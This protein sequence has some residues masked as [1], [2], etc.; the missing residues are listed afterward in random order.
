MLRARTSVSLL[1]VG[2]GAL[3]SGGC[4]D[5]APGGKATVTI[6]R[7]ERASGFVLA[8]TLGLSWGPTAEQKPYCTATLVSSEPPIALTAAHCVQRDGPRVSGVFRPGEPNFV[9]FAPGVLR[10]VREAIPH[11]DWT[12]S[13][14]DVAV[15]TFE[16]PI[17]AGFSPIRIADSETEIERVWS[18]QPQESSGRTVSEFVIAGYGA[19][20]TQGLQ[21]DD[22]LSTTVGLWK[23]WRTGF[24]LG[25][26][27]FESPEG[28]GACYGDSGGPAYYSIDG[29]WVLAGVTHGSHAAF[30]R[31]LPQSM[32]GNCDVGKSIY[33]S[34]ARYKDWIR[35]VV[36]GAKIAGDAELYT[37]WSGTSQ[38]ASFAEA[39]RAGEGLVWDQWATVLQLLL[40]AGTTNCDAAERFFR[41]ATFGDVGG[42]GP[43]PL[44]LTSGR[45]TRFDPAVLPVAPGVR[46]F[47]LG[48][49]FELSR[50][51]LEKLF[52]ALP[53]KLTGLRSLGLTVSSAE[54]LDYALKN[55]PVAELDISY[56]GPKL[57]RGVLGL[58]ARSRL[59]KLALKGFLLEGT[60]ALESPAV[61]DVTVLSP[62][63]GLRVDLRALG[64]D[65]RLERLVVEGADVDWPGV[66]ASLRSLVVR[67]TPAASAWNLNAPRLDRLVVTGR[68]GPSW[69]ILK[70]SRLPQL[71][72]LSLLGTGL[73]DV[74]PLAALV[75]Q[76]RSLDLSCNRVA[77][78][79]GLDWSGVAGP[80]DI[81]AVGNPWQ[82][83]PVC[84]AGTAAGAVRCVFDTHPVF[85]SSVCQVVGSER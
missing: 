18:E 47:A 49:G 83:S 48:N 24:G 61:T 44:A 52:A 81:V 8:H 13:H 68:S 55:A 60:L 29:E 45:P 80:L 62:A 17:P 34:A 4:S 6:V 64:Q 22:L 70:N 40:A 58:S 38:A 32:A 25:L 82:E 79:D 66:L 57:D 5:I 84:P 65:S 27:A 41:T 74:S 31:D 63:G 59:T 54:A 69:S 33:T 21:S 46:V 72:Q 50:A 42:R 16:G 67:D 56:T 85:G 10:A 7:G 2:C 19:T 28:R 1:L 12:I 73:S 39:C 36:P 75:G 35:K 71:K 11:P 43:V 26:L 37:A 30:L 9:Y 15:V 51:D 77:S 23:F 53:G 76:L 3:I 14:A 78:L 20:S